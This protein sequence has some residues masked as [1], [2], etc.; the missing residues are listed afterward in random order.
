MRLWRSW[1]WARVAFWVPPL[2]ALWLALDGLPPKSAPLGADAEG[3]FVMSRYIRPEVWIEGGSREPLWIFGNS[4]VMQIFGETPT[5]LRVTTIVLFVALVVAA[6]LLAR[7]VV[8]PWLA[9]GCGAVLAAS[10]YLVLQSSTGLR[11]EA[12]ALFTVL[13]ALVV[14]HHR[15]G[16]RWPLALAALAGF[17]AMI[18]WDSLIMTLPVVAVAFWL[19]RPTLRQAGA[20]AALFAVIVVPFC[21]G[22]ARNNGDPLHHSNVHS[23]FFRNF[24]FAGKPGYVS[25]A[26]FETNAFAGP[27][28]TWGSYLF[29]D[30]DLG[31]VI[32]RTWEG[33]FNTALTNWSF[34]VFGPEQPPPRWQLTSLGIV[35]SW[36]AALTWALFFLSAAGFVVLLRTRRGW[37]IA[38]MLLLALVQH[39]PIQHLMDARLGLAAT[40]FMVIAAAVALRALWSRALVAAGQAAARAQ[41]AP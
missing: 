29:E 27:E 36:T 30:H 2:Y 35:A 34:T 7:Q 13:V 11:E 18:R 21:V 38:A 1:T 25:R 26:E 19:H 24:E 9:I 14:M 8:G 10:P 12:G 32:D 6:Q 4:I 23:K 28:E 39:A 15:P 16:W 5:T 41:P 20:A 22:N 31:W 33:T 3:Y 17:G 40:P 37:P